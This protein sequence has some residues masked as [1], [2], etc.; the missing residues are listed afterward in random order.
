MSNSSQ[1]LILYRG[2]EDATGYC[3]SLIYRAS[4]N[5]AANRRVLPPLSVRRCRK[6]LFELNLYGDLR[7]ELLNQALSRLAFLPFA[8]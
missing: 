6:S 5:F 3:K 8:F 1:A 4:A 2:G 7:G